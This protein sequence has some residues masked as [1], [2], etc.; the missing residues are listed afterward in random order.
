MKYKFKFISMD[1]I[2]LIN[3]VLSIT[4]NKFNLEV[5]KLYGYD[6]VAIYKKHIN[7]SYI[8]DSYDN[9]YQYS[10][11][12]GLIIKIPYPYIY[13][14]NTHPKILVKNNDKTLYN[15]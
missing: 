6:N 12:L 15:I 10:F 5:L 11:D 3:S 1:D 2:N 8:S 9:L 14:K 13:N 4:D 7:L